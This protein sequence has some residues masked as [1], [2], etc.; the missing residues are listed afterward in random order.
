MIHNGTN[1]I[2]GVSVEVIR[3]RQT[4]YNAELARV[5]RELVEYVVVHELTHLQAANHGPRFYALMDKRLPGWKLRRRTLNKREFEPKLPP[6]P[7]SVRLV[8]SDFTSALFG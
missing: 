2:D 4:T 3:K 5:P 1:L 8:Q 7:K 6:S